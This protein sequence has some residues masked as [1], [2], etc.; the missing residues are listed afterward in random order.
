M[1][2]APTTEE[3]PCGATRSAAEL[4]FE[5]KGGHN[6]DCYRY[7]VFLSIPYLHVIDYSGSRSKEVERRVHAAR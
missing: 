4:S 7:F 5:T 3:F 1:K 2:T 6:E